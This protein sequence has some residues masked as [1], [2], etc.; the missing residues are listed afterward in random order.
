[1]RLRR[2]AGLSGQPDFAL[3]RSCRGKAGPGVM[4]GPARW[5]RGAHYLARHDRLGKPEEGLDSA[6]PMR[7]SKRGLSIHNLIGQAR[8]SGRA[9]TSEPGAGAVLMKEVRVGG[10]RSE[11]RPRPSLRARAGLLT[12]KASEC[13]HQGVCDQVEALACGVGRP[14]RRK[15]LLHFGPR[16]A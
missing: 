5:R 14:C 4:P 11:A 16:S 13:I 1:M 7:C 15:F 3:S 12:A 8:I 2:R 10:R 6:A 9:E